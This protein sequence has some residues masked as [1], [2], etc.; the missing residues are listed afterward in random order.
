MQEEHLEDLRTYDP[1]GWTWGSIWKETQRK[2]SVKGE[3]KGG[4]T[5]SQMWAVWGE[6]SSLFST[7]MAGMTKPDKS[8]TVSARAYCACVFVNAHV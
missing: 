4:L 5:N 2:V 6:P 8:D 3:N 1:K 7:A